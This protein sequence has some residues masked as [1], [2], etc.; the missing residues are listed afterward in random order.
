MPWLPILAAAVAMVGFYSWLTARRLDRLHVRTDVTAAALDDHLL[1]RAAAALAVAEFSHAQ[2]RELCEL[3]IAAKAALAAGGSL[4]HDR[5]V[6]ENDLGD[7][8]LTTVAGLPLNDPDALPVGVV[9]LLDQAMRA[10]F[11][12]RFHNDAVR[13]VLVV[14]TRRVVRWMHLH[15]RAALPS[16]V[17]MDDGLL[18]A[19]PTVSKQVVPLSEP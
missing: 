1:R 18:P 6:V 15:G 5:E 11:A 3:A 8:I 16:Y 10:S 13:D 12:R 9:E 4:G 14:R 17:E 2:D 19:V 7:V